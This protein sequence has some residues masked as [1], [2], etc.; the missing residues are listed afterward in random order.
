MRR[1]VLGC[2]ALLL[3]AVGCGGGNS[4]SSTCDN[5]SNT[6]NGLSGK[7][8]ACGQLPAIP[9]DHNACVQALNG[10]SCSDADRQ[11]INDF[12]SCVNGLPNCTQQTQSSWSSAFVA[13]D[14][15][16]QGISQSCAA[17]AP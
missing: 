3:G 10:N 7:Y 12:A 1:I 4:P 9:F 13:C 14:D 16:L 11:K 17:A 15:K 8:S 5:V 6:L 2:A